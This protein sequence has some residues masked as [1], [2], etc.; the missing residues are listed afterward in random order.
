MFPQEH[1][2]KVPK[3]SETYPLGERG[4]LIGDDWAMALLALSHTPPEHKIYRVM[5]EAGTPAPR[6]FLIRD[7]MLLTGIRTASTLRRGL[8][9][10]I[11]KQS[12]ERQT[13]GNG[14]GKHSYLVRGPRE[15][16]AQRAV[17]QEQFPR[18]MAFSANNGYLERAIRRVVAQSN[19][20]RR[21]AQVAL[22]CAEGLT[23]AGIGARL[24][25]SEQTIKFHLRHVFIKFGVKRRA[26]LIARLL[27]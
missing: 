22:C 19:L 23:N 13:D 9:G 5:V 4:D 21:E 25:V 24:N 17:G 18:T 16:L 10:L 14:S 20:S 7:L 1:H 27:R 12:I 11:T 15:I 26:E 2:V 3:G 6:R 8:E